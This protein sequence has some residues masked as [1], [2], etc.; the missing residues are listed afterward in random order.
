MHTF[1]FKYWAT[2]F[3]KHLRF[4]NTGFHSFALKNSNS[5]CT[6][7]KKVNNN[8]RLLFVYVHSGLFLVYQII[9]K[10]S[11]QNSEQRCGKRVDATHRACAELFLLVCSVTSPWRH[12]NRRGYPQSA[13]LSAVFFLYNSWNCVHYLSGTYFYIWVNGYLASVLSRLA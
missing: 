8:L 2:Y 5:Q 12:A 1:G 9:E 13:V 7:S 4:C 6:T 3:C 10:H 11:T